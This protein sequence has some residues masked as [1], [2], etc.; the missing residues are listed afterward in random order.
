MEQVNSLA[1]NQSQLDKTDINVVEIIGA[2]V[3]LRKAGRQYIGLCPFHQEKTPSFY[4]HPDRGFHCWGCGAKGD[5]IRF[6]REIEGIS[7]RE[8]ID[9]LGVDYTPVHRDPRK[10]HA[11][12]LLAGWLNGNFLKVGARLLELSRDIG[13]AMEIPDPELADSLEC[14]WEVLSVLHEDLQNLEFA[15]DLLNCRD[16]IDRIIEDS[17]VEAPE[18]FPELTPQYRAYLQSIHTGVLAC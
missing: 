1:R 18:Y 11:A 12:A 4:V 2:Y 5:V 6:V 16:A 15:E 9:R 13:L 10:H 8:A 7:F 14:E 17:P 3:D